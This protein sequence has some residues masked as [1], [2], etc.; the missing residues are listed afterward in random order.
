MPER[1]QLRRVRGWKMPPNT[2]SVARPSLW[3]NPYKVPRDGDAAECV[4]KYRACLM[5]FKHGEGLD[6]FLHEEANIRAVQNDLRGVNLAC[7][8]DLKSPCHADVLL[9]IANDEFLT[10]NAEQK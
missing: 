5:P 4:R 2:I 3:G 1:V 9:E 8:C 6:K 10:P 7:Y